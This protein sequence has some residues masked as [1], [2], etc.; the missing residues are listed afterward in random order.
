MRLAERD[1]E[2]SEL[3]ALADAVSG[4]RGG[5]AVVSGSRGCGRT[6][7]LAA[8]GEAGRRAGVRTLVLTGLRQADTA[9]DTVD[10]LGA[11]RAHLG[12]PVDSGPEE[13]VAALL[14]GGPAVVT[15]DDVNRA[16]GA[17]LDLVRALVRRVADSPVVVILGVREGGGDFSRYSTLLAAATYLVTLGP[18]SI[19][20]TREVLHARMGRAPETAMVTWVYAITGGN[21]AL[22]HATMDDLG[23]CTSAPPGGVTCMIGY[24]QAVRSLLLTA[25]DQGTIA[26]VRA[27]AVL[28]DAC[29][30]D[31][32]VA[33][34]EV[35]ERDTRRIIAQLRAAGLVKREAV[36][37]PEV[38][39]VVLGGTAAD[40][41]DALHKQAA[42]LL[43]GRGGPVGQVAHH[44]CAL[45]S[46]REPWAVA[47]LCEAAEVSSRRGG[48]RHALTLLGLAR[49][50]SGDPAE[51]AEIDTRLADVHWWL[52]VDR[53]SRRFDTIAGTGTAGL[54]APSLALL[55]RR[56]AWQGRPNAAARVLDRAEEAGPGQ[57]E[58]AIARVWAHHLYPGV[59]AA[60]C[61]TDPR[62]GWDQ[63]AA[64]SPW[65][66]AAIELTAT[67]GTG[68]EDRVVECAQQV[69]EQVT[70]RP[71]DLEPLH[72]AL[73]ALLATERFDPEEQAFAR[74][75]GEDGVEFPT[76][77]RTAVL[78]AAA[79]H[80][81]ARGDLR[82]A[83]AQA[84][85]ALALVDDEVDSV[86]AGLAI[87]V[88]LL[89]LTEQ[90]RHEEVAQY[91]AQPLPESCARTPYGLL[92]LRARGRHHLA[93]GAVRAAIVDFRSCGQ[94]LA[95][96]GLELPGLLPW[97]VDLAEALT[98]LGHVE[99]AR[100]WAVEHLGHVPAADS[101]TRG[102]ALR[103]QA[104]T[105]SGDR[106]QAL[107][108][109]AVTALERC[110]DRL[111]QA[112]ALAALAERHHAAGEVT[113][114]RFIL[115]R[116]IKLARSCGG[117]LALAGMPADEPDLDEI[118]VLV[119]RQAEHDRLT[120]TEAKVAR[121]ASQGF[122]NREIAVSLYVTVSTVEQH[123]TRIYRKLSVR[124]R[125]E[126]GE[127]VGA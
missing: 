16:D 127:F 108:R 121:L 73:F 81:L 87:G 65:L 75:A 40:E 64:S 13:V 117:R 106:A 116:A 11:M 92:R 109:M 126:L 85:E 98:E 114:G 50:W 2:L 113:V 125:A 28:G 95:E 49:R 58:P 112:R 74:L 31:L 124:T 122:T 107:L 51:R 54:P 68:S 23:E 56:L 99:E 39:E 96:W 17:S 86:P 69:M 1:G 111:E 20:G 103:A 44:L 36:L 4:G 6:A 80:A 104:G 32:L 119:A 53:V 59:V 66:G 18:L 47:V 3:T 37:R 93:T 100:K 26:V 63:V 88:R 46:V 94:V 12:M 89:A 78:S 62:L 8:A 97:R 102:L 83:V 120:A 15:I 52:R 67:L 118:D 48:L 84:T 42:E 24:V 7:L 110:G 34:S 82:G 91:L 105:L 76:R 5:M 35:D 45:R 79:A 10:V 19:D 41:R 71:A 77:F 9:T 29:D 115:R 57:V 21:P 61:A 43:Y 14:D 38:C 60:P 55:A 25:L 70:S 30:H 22:V 33:L 123:L 72:L 27:A 101:R 90:D